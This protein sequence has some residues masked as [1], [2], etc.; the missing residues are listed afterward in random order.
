MD[1]YVSIH[2]TSQPTLTSQ[3]SWKPTGT[4]PKEKTYTSTQVLRCSE[5]IGFPVILRRDS[6]I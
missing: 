5:S 3:M 6:L 1:N 4:L 2:L